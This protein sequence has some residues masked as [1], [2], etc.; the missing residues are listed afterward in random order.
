MLGVPREHTDWMV[1]RYEGR[2]SRIVFDDYTSAPFAVDGG[3]DQG[4]PHSGICFLL[5]GTGLATIPEPKNGENSVVFV[6][7]NTLITTGADF[8]VM[9]AKLVDVVQRLGGIN[10]WASEH[11]ALFGPAK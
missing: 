4:D 10:K 9:H 6:D 8:T 11:N 3:L 1:R 2:T 7:D 5:Y